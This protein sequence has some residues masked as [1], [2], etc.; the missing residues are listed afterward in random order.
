[1]SAPE[2]VA[3]KAPHLGLMIPDQQ[4]HAD[5]AKP[6][7][8]SDDSCLSME[9]GSGAAAVRSLQALLCAGVGHRVVV[10]ELIANGVSD[11]QDFEWLRQ[12]RSYWHTG[13]L[14]C[15]RR[16]GL[17][18]VKRV[19]KELVCAVSVPVGMVRLDGCSSNV[20]W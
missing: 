14:T 10:E 4:T 6:P 5:A 8:S 19:W 20:R 9:S 13:R 1:M 15:T 2:M 17:R 12:M 18:E 16:Y 7:A 11:E 3:T